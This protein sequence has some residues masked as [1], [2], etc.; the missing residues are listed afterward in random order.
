MRASK[1][2]PAKPI[3]L[4]PNSGLSAPPRLQPA[5]SGSDPKQRKIAGAAAEIADQDEFV[6]V[7]RGF[8]MMGGGNGLQFKSHFFEAGGEKSFR[9]PV[10]RKKVVFFLSGAHEID[11]AAHHCRINGDAELCLCPFPQVAEN[12]RDQILHLE[13]AAKDIRAF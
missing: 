4:L 5:H 2:S 11:R 12:P 9:Q 8:V 1:A 10:N 3:P 13:S 6:V 7:K